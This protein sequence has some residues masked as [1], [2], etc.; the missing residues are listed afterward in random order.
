MKRIFAMLLVLLFLVSCGDPIETVGTS[1]QN[2]NSPSGDVT[3]APETDAPE[4][5]APEEVDEYSE[6]SAIVPMG[7]NKFKL[8]FANGVATEFDGAKAVAAF[9]SAVVNGYAGSA[10]GWISTSAL[11]VEGQF[12]RGTDIGAKAFGKAL[13]TMLEN[14]DSYFTVGGQVGTKEIAVLESE[15]F[16]A[17]NGDIRANSETQTYRYTQRIPV[18]AGQTF[19][20]YSSGEAQSMRF[21]TVFQNGVA[22]V[23]Q[24]M[25]DP[26]CTTKKF[27]APEGATHLVGTYK[28]TGAPVVAHVTGKTEAKPILKSKVDGETIMELITGAPVESTPNLSTAADS[29]K[30]NY[31]KLEANDKMHNKTLKLTFNIS[32]LKEGEMIVLGHGETSYGGSAIELTSDGVRSYNYFNE[33]TDVFSDFHGIELSGDIEI[34]IQVGIGS[35]TVSVENAEEKY[36][37][38]SFLWYGRQGEIFAKTVGV[39]IENVEL[40][41]SCS[42]YDK[43][44]WILGDSYLNTA[45]VDRWPYYLNEDGY[46]EYFMSGFP[47][48]N[49]QQ[50]IVDFKKAL[51]HGTPKFAVWCI[52]MNNKDT[53]TAISKTYKEST[54]EFLRVCE[55]KGITPVLT[56]TPNTPRCINIHKNEW[57]KSSGYRYI[58]FAAAV[59]AEEINSSWTQGMI[60]GDNV[61]PAPTGAEALYKQFIKDFPEIKQ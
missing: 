36:V 57:V 37:S 22:N 13:A 55:E 6:L 18:V 52:G 44:I 5:D 7:D 32:E 42:D 61:H 23:E 60:S 46:T 29:L 49:G 38:D 28:Y 12:Y 21:I 47:G 14:Y 8:T 33:R 58:D 9:D 15:G 48:R 39:A 20:I 56:T 45:T 27:V 16:M 41:W 26:S 34:N 59:D 30:D 24:A 50:A 53:E 19:E 25:V 17:Q 40:E 2:T 51:E 43:E 54:D 35:A 11:M 3:N 31:L 1:D 4:T 10:P